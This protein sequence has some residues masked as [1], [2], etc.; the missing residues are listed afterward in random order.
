VLQT[1]G[2][3]TGEISGLASATL[4]I[5]NNSVHVLNSQPFV[6]V[7]SIRTRAP[8]LLSCSVGLMRSIP[9][10]VIQT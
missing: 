3:I 9:G 8:I 5:N 6:F 7:K 1:L 4:T 2:K 10:K